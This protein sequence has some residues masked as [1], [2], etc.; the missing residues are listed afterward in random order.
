MVGNVYDLQTGA[1]INDATVTVDEADA[2]AETLATPADENL[3]DGFYLLFSPLTGPTD[4][5]ADKRLFAPS[6]E[7]VDV[8][9]D[10][11]VRQ[12]FQL[13]SG[14]FVVDPDAARGRSGPRRV[15]RPDVDPHQR[16]DRRG[17]VR[18]RERDRGPGH[19][20]RRRR[21]GGA[22]RGRVLAPGDRWSGVGVVGGRE[23]G[24]RRWVG[25][26]PASPDW[27]AGAPVPAG[28]LRYVFATCEDN[29]EVFYVISGV[30]N[31]DIVNTNYR[32]DAATDTWSTLAPIPTGQEGPDAACF[33]GRIYTIGGGGSNQ[34]F[35]YDIAADTWS[36][37][38]PVPRGSAMASAGAFDDKVFYIGGDNDFTPGTGVFNQVYIYDIASNSWSEGTA[39]PTAT[40]GAGTVQVGQF[41]YVVGGWGSGAP[42]SNVNATQRY[43]MAADTWETGPQFTVAKAD[44]RAG[45]VGGVAVRD[46]G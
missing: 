33:D 23:G 8:V 42:G 29:P 39:M 15:G 10:G 34:H 43:D 20:R 44:H 14:Q 40:S 35:V 26:R 46:R 7:T 4:I 30:S 6:T 18:V 38:A 21:V 11:V 24:R 28:I 17:R 5:T 9:A 1:P 3:D 41:L 32:Y 27:Q 22:G 45:R 13:G 16:G 2:G 36:A 25:G 12:D 37:A 31:G 19:P